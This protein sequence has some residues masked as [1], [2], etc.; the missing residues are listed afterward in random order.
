M[1][2]IVI[3]IVLVTMVLLLLYKYRKKFIPKIEEIINHYKSKLD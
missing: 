2:N 1:T 3:Y